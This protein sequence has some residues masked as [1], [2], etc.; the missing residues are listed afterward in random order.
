MVVGF[1]ISALGVLRLMFL[2]VARLEFL[3]VLLIS[4]S[5]RGGF[6]LLCVAWYG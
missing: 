5:F 3:F 2:V 1:A 4:V 6:L